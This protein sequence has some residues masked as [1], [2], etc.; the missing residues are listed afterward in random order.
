MV[1]AKTSVGKEVGWSRGV[2]D[3]GWAKVKEEGRRKRG[4][5]RDEE[6]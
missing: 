6:G 1:E 3:G 2:V 5:K 4:E